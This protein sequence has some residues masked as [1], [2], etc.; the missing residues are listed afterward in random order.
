MFFFFGAASTV[1]YCLTN[2]SMSKLFLQ[3]YQMAFAGEYNE[4]MFFNA[5][6]DTRGV[7]WGSRFLIYCV[8]GIVIMVAL[9]NIFIGIMSNKFDYF[10]ERC[11]SLFVR[12]RARMALDYSLLGGYTNRSDHLW[13]STEIVG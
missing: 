5:G 9:N 6:D 7:D 2:D 4:E 11:I 10:E 3:T 8:A 13:F 12:H 1:G